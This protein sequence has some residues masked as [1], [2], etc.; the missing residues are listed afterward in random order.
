MKIQKIIP[1]FFIALIFG[2][3]L[4]SPEVSAVAQVPTPSA[5]F[6]PPSSTPTSGFFDCPVGTPLGWGT[7]TPSAGWIL[8]CGDCASITTPTATGIPSTPNPTQYAVQTQQAIC[9][10]AVVGGGVTPEGCGNFPTPT[11][12]PTSI[13]TVTPNATQM[14]CGGFTISFVSQSAG[15]FPSSGS[16]IC[17]PEGSNVRCQGTL[18]QTDQHDTTDQMMTMFFS[19]TGLTAGQTLDISGVFSISSVYGVYP[20]LPI[21]FTGFGFFGSGSPNPRPSNW[22]LT[23]GSPSPNGEFNIAMYGGGIAGTVITYTV[24][25][26]FSR[27]VTCSNLPT[28]TP[29]PSA[30]PF[31]DVGYCSSVAPT[32]SEFGFDLF[33]PDGEP[34]C[35]MGWDEFGVGEY[36]VPAVQICF[37]PS[38]FGVIRLFGKDYEV[39]VYGLAAAAAFLWRYFRTV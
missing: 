23:L 8:E 1:L 7:Y 2:I 37:Q 27:S 31:I 3:V 35:D 14:A 12:T 22:S 26:L 39:G 21:F 28:P 25:I 38:Q 15:I 32:I 4:F 20:T 9:Q 16:L 13:I 34:N 11:I 33:V 18:T 30:T 6:I 19:S 36:T 10:T 17:S 24:D 5:T 29:S